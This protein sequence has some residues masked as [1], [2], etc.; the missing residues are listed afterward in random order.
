MGSRTDALGNFIEIRD[1][2]SAEIGPYWMAAPE[3][4]S[5]VP[6]GVR[7]AQCGRLR[8][9]FTPSPDTAVSRRRIGDWSGANLAIRLPQ[10]E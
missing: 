10:G 3:E 9:Y 4:P 1:K 6:E 2:L 5:R 8:T 7:D